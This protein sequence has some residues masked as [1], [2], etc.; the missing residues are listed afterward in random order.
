MIP[1][2]VHKRIIEHQTFSLLPMPGFTIDLKRTVAVRYLDSQMA[3][4]SQIGWTSM[5]FNVGS[6]I[7]L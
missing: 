2:L 6:G 7:E 4:Q 5:R 1:R 3:T